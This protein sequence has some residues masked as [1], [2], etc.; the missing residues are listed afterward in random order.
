MGGIGSNLVSD[1][2]SD[3]SWYMNPNRDLIEQAKRASLE[4]LL[5]KNNDDYDPNADYDVGQGNSRGSGSDELKQLKAEN[6]KL[7]ALNK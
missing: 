5:G 3:V 4:G 7:R 6:A 1:A 2:L